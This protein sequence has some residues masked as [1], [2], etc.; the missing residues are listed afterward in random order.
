MLCGYRSNF[1]LKVV[2]NVLELVIHH[3]YRLPQE[4]VGSSL[5]HSYLFGKMEEHYQLSEG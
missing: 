3:Y 2:D 1:G 5:R 4:G